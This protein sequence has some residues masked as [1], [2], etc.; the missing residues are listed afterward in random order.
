MSLN[1]KSR[2]NPPPCL[3]SLRKPLLSVALP[4]MAA[5]L[6]LAFACAPRPWKNPEQRLRYMFRMVHELSVPADRSCAQEI[7]RNIRGAAGGAVHA[8]SPFGEEACRKVLSACGN[9][10]LPKVGW[11]RYSITVADKNDRV[12]NET[13]RPVRSYWGGLIIQPP[14]TGH[15]IRPLPRGV[16][17]KDIIKSE[18]RTKNA[19]PAKAWNY[20]GLTRRGRV[21]RKMLSLSVRLKVSCTRCHERRGDY[22]LNK[23]GERYKKTGRLE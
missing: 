20:H 12:Y 4:S 13:G 22:K 21:A 16:D 2:Y 1:I 7:G 17:L 15:F 18:L 11:Y 8:S 3:Q 10:H 9:C 6:G 5:L 23:R 14:N 19:S